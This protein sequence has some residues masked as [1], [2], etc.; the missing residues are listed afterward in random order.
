MKKWKIIPIITS[1]IGATF[2]GIDS[3]IDYY[4]FS[5]E[6]SLFDAFFTDE[7]REIWM[8]LIV[9]LLF[10]IAGLY[11][12]KTV[13]KLEDSRVTLSETIK[14]LNSEIDANRILQKKL[15][16]Q[17]NTDFLTSISNRREFFYQLNKEFERARR[18]GRTFSIAM[19]D[20]DHF[21]QVN[22][23]LGHHEG[24]LILQKFSKVIGKM[25]R[26]ADIFARLGGEEFAIIV[27]DTS[28]EKALIMSEKMHKTTTEYF[29]DNIF[30]I[31]ISIGIS[32][33][34]NT[35]NVNTLMQRADKALYTAKRKGR[36]RTE[37][38]KIN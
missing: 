32:E 17:A 16:S 1:I 11:A 25:I 4:F 26:T 37:I 24:D 3:L 7:P 31:T 2:W 29:K 12:S 33:F 9:F 19:I 6:E 30:N 8:R 38:I 22:D 36:N 5:T 21:K 14:K 35:D 18:Y 15:H 27:P 10:I 20:L 34:S 13:K 28:I 23:K